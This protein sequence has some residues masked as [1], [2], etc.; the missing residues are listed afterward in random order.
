MARPVVFR[1]QIFSLMHFLLVVPL[2]PFFVAVFAFLL[3]GRSYDMP[4]FEEGN[5]RSD[6]FVEVL[7][8]HEGPMGIPRL[9]ADLNAFENLLFVDFECGEILR[10]KYVGRAME[11]R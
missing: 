2:R 4:L 9:L 3:V 7:L 6:P 1:S 5:R 11:A 10:S 8:V